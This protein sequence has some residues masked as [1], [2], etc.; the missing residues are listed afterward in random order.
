MAVRFIVSLVFAILVAIFALQNSG[1]VTIKFLFFQSN[2]SQALV[3]LIS[4]V[5]GAI[6]VLILS[7]IAQIK[8]NHTVKSS[9]K[10]ITA[11]EE[12]KKL[13]SDKIDEL[14]KQANSQITNSSIN[15]EGEGNEV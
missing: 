7:T 5:V 4:A 1:S 13:L 2:I 10:A 9:A 15:N 8:L 6:I 12:E 11:L 14:L 3:I